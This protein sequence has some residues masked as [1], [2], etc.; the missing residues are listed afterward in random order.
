MKLISVAIGKDSLF[1]LHT[2]SAGVIWMPRMTRQA[3]AVTHE[4]LLLHMQNMG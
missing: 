1:L 3:D 4:D 2:L